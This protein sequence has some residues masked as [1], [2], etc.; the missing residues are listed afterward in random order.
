MGLLTGRLLIDII[1]SSSELLFY[2]HFSKGCFNYKISQLSEALN[3]EELKQLQQVNLTN[4][5]LDIIQFKHNI[6]YSLLQ[7]VLHNTQ[8]H[9]T[10]IS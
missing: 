5:Q 7:K 2:T 1:L 8:Y 4:D 6:M 3:A 9:N 10:K